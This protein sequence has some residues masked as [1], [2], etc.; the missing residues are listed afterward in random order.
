MSLLQPPSGQ[1]LGPLRSFARVLRKRAKRL[2]SYF[3]WSYLRLRNVAARQSVTGPTPVV[4]SLTTYGRRIDAAAVAVES[5]ARGSIKPSRIILWLDNPSLYANR[6]AALRRLEYRGLEILLTDNLGPHTKYFP[7]VGS[8]KE[9][10]L[11]LVTADDDIMYPKYWLRKLHRSYLENP[12]SINCHW[13]ST[14]LLSGDRVGSYHTWPNCRTSAPGFSN[15]GLGVS[16]VIYPP[17]M[18][19]ELARQGTAFRELS[20][21]ADDVWLHWVAL[22]AGYPVRQIAST[23][24]HFALIPGTQAQALMTTNNVEGAGNDAWIGRLYSESDRSKIYSAISV[25]PGSA[26]VGAVGQSQDLSPGVVGRGPCLPVDAM[27]D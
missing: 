20:P 3:M 5:I 23:P 25:V 8:V 21:T 27:F 13:A 11:P 4:V 26:V 22:R 19:A 16:G 15:F 10:L 14:I 7:Y 9:H 18:L 17:G 6:P 2:R 12:T 1:P 24:R